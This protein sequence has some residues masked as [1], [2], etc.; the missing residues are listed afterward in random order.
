MAGIT[1]QPRTQEQ[2]HN[3]LMIHWLEIIAI[4]LNRLIELL[5]SKEKQD[6]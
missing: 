6:G 4:K 5:E 2:E 3:E 1:S